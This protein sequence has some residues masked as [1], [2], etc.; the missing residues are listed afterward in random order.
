MKLYELNIPTF[1]L[2]EQNNEKLLHHPI[3]PVQVEQ[4]IMLFQWR[5]IPGAATVSGAERGRQ[6]R[7]HL[8]EQPGVYSSTA[9]QTPK[10]QNAEG[11]N[12]S[13]TRPVPYGRTA[14]FM[15]N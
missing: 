10:N 8:Q 12:Q 7:P 2:A 15:F 6:V 14:V 3:Q 4:C 11:Q 1:K 5:W 9:S 13:Q